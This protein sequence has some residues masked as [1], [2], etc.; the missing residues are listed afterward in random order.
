VSS[1]QLS[2]NITVRGNLLRGNGSAAIGVSVGWVKGVRVITN[3]VQ[4]YA[5]GINW[6]GGDANPAR[7]GNPSNPRWAIDLQIENNTVIKSGGGGI[8]GSMG[9]QVAARWNYVDGCG[10]VCLDAEGS[11]EVLFENN[12]AANAAN[13][14]LA[15]FFN[16]QD[17]RF[18]NNR[19]IQNGSVNP[20]WSSFLRQCNPTLV[21]AAS[22]IN[23][24]IA[25]N[26][27]IYSNYTGLGSLGKDT[28]MM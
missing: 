27:F 10:D 15:V 1:S 13:G 4:G 21:G 11:N 14:V 3:I 16:S 19:C 2:Q 22:R 20:T 12:N 23:V 28:G 7:G 17:V 8:W 5:H 9:Q 26:S 18:V 24:T 6:W 25:H